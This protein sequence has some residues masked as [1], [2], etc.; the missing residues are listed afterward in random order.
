MEMERSMKVLV[1]GGAGFTD[2]FK[3]SVKGYFC[4]LQL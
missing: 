4:D 2:D 3:G 1:T